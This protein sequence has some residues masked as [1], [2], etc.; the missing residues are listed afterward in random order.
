MKKLFLFITLLLTISMT[1]TAFADRGGRGR[2]GWGGGNTYNY[3][4]NR[5]CGWNGNQFWG[6]FAGGAAGALVAGI[7]TAP[8]PTMVVE[9]V[10]TVEPVYVPTYRQY[11]TY[12]VNGV[13]Y[14]EE[15]RQIIRC[16]KCGRN[17]DCASVAPGCNA[18]CPVCGLILL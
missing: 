8:Q 3:Y 18:Q 17:V 4:G 15:I 13:E 14:R 7:L 2:G 12:Y 1:S 10:A 6:S 5:G 9:R 11:R 16:P